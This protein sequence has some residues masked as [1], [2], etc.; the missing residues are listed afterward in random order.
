MTRVFT[1]ADM[2]NHAMDIIAVQNGNHGAMANQKKEWRDRDTRFQ[3]I[4]ETWDDQFADG[5][6][7]AYNAPVLVYLR[8][9]AHLNGFVL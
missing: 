4:A 7:A 8:S 5:E 2:S 1:Q 6:I 9:F 3:H